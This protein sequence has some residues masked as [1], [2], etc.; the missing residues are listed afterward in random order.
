[1]NIFSEKGNNSI[2][3][4]RN[5]EEKLVLRLAR[6]GQR[7]ARERL[8]RLFFDAGYGL[9]LRLTQNS[10]DA[11]DLIQDAFLEVFRSL[12]RFD[13]SQPFLP[14]FRKIIVHRYQKMRRKKQLISRIFPFSG[15]P[16]FDPDLFEMSGSSPE[17]AL[18]RQEEKEILLKA[19]SQLPE[20][21]RV[22]VVL[23]D[24]EGLNQKEI[25]A[26]LDVPVGT[27]MS[28]LHYGRRKLREQ[29]L[30]YFKERK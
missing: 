22:V 24:L 2:E 6:A 13:L 20:N 17:L 25:A 23:F 3:A 12:E 21:Q 11:D 27:V 15:K 8:A 29:L 9:A 30:P 28:R 1:M 26:I 4:Q 19:L 7:E 10:R 5:P 18:R 14:W 16:H